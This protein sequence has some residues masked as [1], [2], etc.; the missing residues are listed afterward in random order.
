MSARL[1][2]ATTLE[3]MYAT[4]GTEAPTGSGWSFEPKYD[5]MR[6]LAFVTSAR[7]RLM[8]RNGK[9]KAKQ[10]P[11]V[12]T[13]LGALGRRLGRRCVFDGEVVALDRNR[14][15]HFQALQGRFHLKSGAD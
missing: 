12:V 7:V 10:F 11:E 9:D 6:A 8:T 13:A 3:P 5:G 4:I 1:P 14:P 2:S 15:G